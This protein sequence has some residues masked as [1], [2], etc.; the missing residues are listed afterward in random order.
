[1]TARI[2]H[3]IRSNSGTE[4]PSLAVFVDTETRPVPLDPVTVENV[5]VFGWA[6]RIRRKRDFEWT[7][8]LWTRFTTHG[9]FWRWVIAATHEG[10]KLFIFCH[11]TNFDLPVLKTFAYLRRRGWKLH[12]AVIEGPPTILEWRKGRATICVIDTL[13]FWR[14]SLA[15]IGKSVGLP[16]LRMPPPE[17]S[18]ARWN[19]YC[20]RDVKVILRAMLRWW[21]MLIQHDFGGFAPTVA[22]QSMR[23]WRHRFMRHEVLVHD[24]ERA[25]RLERACYYGGRNEAFYLGKI[26]SPIY[27]TDIKSAYP[28][29]M[30]DEL[31]PCRLAGI[32]FGAAHSTLAL[33]DKGYAVA[34]EVLVH[35]EVPVIPKLAESRL[36]FPVGT[37]WTVLT[38]V[39]I[40]EVLK[41]G[42]I[43]EIGWSGAWHVAPLFRDFVK[44]IFALRY[45]ALERGDDSQVEFLKKILN[46]LYGKFGQN[47]FKWDRDRWEP[48]E[49]DG[50]WIEY[51]YE[52]GESRYCR[53]LSGLTQR[54]RR[55]AE[56]RESVPIIAAFVT[57]YQRVRLLD[58]IRTAGFDQTVYCDTDSVFVTP[59]GYARLKP[60]LA[61]H[62]LG[63]LETKGRASNMEIRGLKDY[64]FGDENHVKGVR[65]NADWLDD[66]T[67]VQNQWSG[68]RGAALRGNIDT[69]TIRRQTKHLTRSYTK[70]TRLPTGRVEPLRYD[71]SASD[72]LLPRP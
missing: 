17:A 65:D 39:E 5:L 48:A 54:K 16:K 25:L 49:P 37:F 7:K 69:Q 68:L 2:R 19:A 55:D 4:L 13:N 33:A 30:H 21:S 71:E 50:S 23:I 27:Y 32:D 58:I 44:E 56:S 34:A 29:V 12:K 59:D 46:S 1:M 64:T 24:D 47:G 15:T 43:L 62:G 51:D 38:G 45:A 9:A 35:T 8:P 61:R 18:E 66:S 6:C 3:Y 40:A 67:I 36:M 28:A 31:Y 63:A 41:V 20:R 22:S 57:S 42:E 53:R 72:Y 60:Y 52:T 26:R 11:N 14:Q 10:G 70:G